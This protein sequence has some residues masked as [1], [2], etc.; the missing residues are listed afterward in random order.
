MAKRT[1]VILRAEVID[2]GRTGDVLDVAPGYARNYLIPRGLALPATEANKRRIDQERSKLEVRMREEK[3]RAEA[4]AARLAGTEMVFRMMA[5]EE[6]QL[7]GSVSVGDI[8]DR[9]EEMGHAVDRSQVR[10]DQP[11]KRLGETEVPIR[12]HAEV[13]ATVLVK[14]ERESA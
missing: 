14:V 11:I 5:G 4:A 9:L 10:L 2:L 12:F 7:Y 3:E 6:D 8:A 1:E 13:T